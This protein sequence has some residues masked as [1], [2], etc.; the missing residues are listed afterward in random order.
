MDRTSGG[1]LMNV[2]CE[3]DCCAFLLIEMRKPTIAIRLDFIAGHRG[4]PY[5]VAN[6]MARRRQTAG[7]ADIGED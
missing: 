7:H 1:L 2:T 4:R 5:I 3:Y 6:K